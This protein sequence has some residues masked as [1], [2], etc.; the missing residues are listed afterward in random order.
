L[1][2]PGRGHLAD[3]HLG[4]EALAHQAAVVIGESG[5]HGLDLAFLHPGAQLFQRQHAP[6]LHGFFR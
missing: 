6:L 5:D 4:V 1:V 3:E 2:T